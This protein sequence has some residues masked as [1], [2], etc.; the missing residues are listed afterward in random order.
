RLLALP[1]EL[2]R[3]PRGFLFEGSHPVRVVRRLPRES[4][5]E[6]LELDRRIL[7]VLLLVARTSDAGWIDPRVSLP[8]L[9]AALAPVGDRVEVVVPPDGSLTALTDALAEAERQGRPFHVVH[10]DGHG[11]YDRDKGLGQLVFE[12]DQDCVDGNIERKTRLIDAKHI[13]GLLKD[14]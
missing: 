9:V 13:G 3:G 1:W 12:D 11:V 8:P 5:R 2:L 10:F 7:R 4:V 6:A 14:H